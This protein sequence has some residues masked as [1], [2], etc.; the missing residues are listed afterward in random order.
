MPRTEALKKAQHKYQ[1]KTVKTVAVKLHSVLDSDIINRLDTVDS[2]QGYI[3]TLIRGEIYRDELNELMELYGRV[4]KKN[5]NSIGTDV[6]EYRI[7]RFYEYGLISVEKYKEMID[8]LTKLRKSQL[9]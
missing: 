1:Q 7:E 4:S 9:M 6:L 2:K 8:F 5:I 3:K